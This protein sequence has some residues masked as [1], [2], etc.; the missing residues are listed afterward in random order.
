M[1]QGAIFDLDGTLFDSNPIWSNIG[2]RYLLSIGITPKE[3]LAEAFRTASLYQAACHIIDEYKV[4]LT[5]HE[6]M[7]GVNRLVEGFYEKEAELKSGVYEFLRRLNE[8]GV[9]MCIA[10]ATDRHLVRAALERVG[11]SE[12]FSEIFTCN[13]VGASKDDPKIYREALAHLETEKA[14][15]P[16]FEDSLFALMTAKNDNFTVVGIKDDEEKYPASM[17]REAHYYLENYNDIDGLFDFLG[18]I[19]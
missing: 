3:N 11:I 16:V 6:I 10:T 7:D 2:E 5:A 12:F 14:L 9:K 13:S 17:R 4:S 15:T 19:V 8:A 18:G 1:I